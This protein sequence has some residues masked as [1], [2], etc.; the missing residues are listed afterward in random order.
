MI[1]YCGDGLT[2][3]IKPEEIKGDERK[4]KA[5]EFKGWIKSN[6]VKLIVE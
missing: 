4:Y 2:E 3:L 1:Y 6:T 5:T